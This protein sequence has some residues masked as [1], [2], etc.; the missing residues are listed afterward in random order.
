MF[1]PRSGSSFPLSQN[2]P[3]LCISAGTL[4]CCASDI[5]ASSPIGHL[6]N[7]TPLSS[8]GSAASIWLRPA[9]LTFCCCCALDFSM[10]LSI[11]PQFWMHI[12]SHP[13]TVKTL[14]RNAHCPS[15]LG[16]P[17]SLYQ[18]KLGSGISTFPYMSIVLRGS[19][20]VERGMTF[21]AGS[22]RSATAPDEELKTTTA[23]TM[24]KAAAPASK[25]NTLPDIFRSPPSTAGDGPI[26][27]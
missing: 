20:T 26:D 17:E 4:A 2:C 1:T 21:P 12:W 5:S 24:P 22:S 19:F 8:S 16:S 13:S 27:P 14:S 7:T 15:Q 18:L 25:A 11:S 23:T 3:Q 6:S 10:M 9:S